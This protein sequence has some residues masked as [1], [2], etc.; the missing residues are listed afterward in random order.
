MK[1]PFQNPGDAISLFNKVEVIEGFFNYDDAQHFHLMLKMQEIYHTTG[2]LMEIGTWKGRSA[3]YISF[4]VQS[5]EQ[6][7]LLDAFSKPASDKY[8]EYPTIDEVSAN[9][10]NLNQNID[11]SRIIFIQ[12]NS[13]EI[14]FP[15]NTKLRFSHIDGGHSFE[16]CYSDLINVS[17]RTVKNGLIVVDDYDHPEW[18][19]VKQAVDS[20][21]ANNPNFKKVAVMN[22]ND[23]KGTKFYIVRAFY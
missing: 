16:E 14:A 11:L 12:G 1:A 22:R 5:N 2:D 17:K 15:Q 21:L 18:P 20:W 13:S 4:F 23:A 6:L 10:T 3:A 19:E 8:P 7:I 9:I